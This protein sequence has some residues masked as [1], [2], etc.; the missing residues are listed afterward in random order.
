MAANTFPIRRTRTR[1]LRALA[2]V[3]SALIAMTMVAG[4]ASATIIERER[5]TNHYEFTAWDC[6]YPMQV[7]GDD[8]PPDP[9]P[10]RQQELDGNVFFT[11][12]YQFR[13]TW[14][15]AD[16]R[17]FTLSGNGHLQGHQ[18]QVSSAGRCTSSRF[19]ETGQPVVI[20]DSLRQGRLPRPR[21]PH[22]QLHDR[23]RRRDEF[24]FLGFQLQGT[25]PDVRRG[26]VRGRGTARRAAHQRGLG[27]VPDATADRL[28][29]LPDGLLRIP[30]A[31]LYRERCE[32]PAAPVLQRLRRERRRHP[33]GAPDGSSTR[34]SRSYIN[35]G[36][37]PTDRPFVV[38]APQH[39]EDP[40]GFDFSLVRRRRRGA[41][42]ATCSSSTIAATRNPPS[43]R[44]RTRSTTSSTMRWPTTTSTRRGCTSPGCRAVRSGSGS[45]WRS[46]RRP[47]GGGRCPDRRRRTSRLLSGLLRRSARRRS[48]RS[49]ARSTTWSTRWEA[50]NR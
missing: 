14:T 44:R 46:T 10:R 38:L 28:D 33:R 7:V 26:P 42:P 2:V 25:A 47:E 12:N 15:A 13:E 8:V 34:A 24:N 37:W 21:E 35:V 30:A 48:G 41:G 16:G 18:G 50:S 29:R 9:G 4:T 49:T 3:G 23:L 27:P 5:F 32:E 36:G 1:R 22:R 20:T 40:P 45:T 43:A 11:D 39:V 17:S 6:G 31:E 19:H